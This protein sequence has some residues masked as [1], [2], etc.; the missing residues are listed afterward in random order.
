MEDIRRFSLMKK[1]GTL[2]FI[3]IITDKNKYAKVQKGYERCGRSFLGVHH[4][5]MEQVETNIYQ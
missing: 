2:D 3:T 4:P 1:K 5:I